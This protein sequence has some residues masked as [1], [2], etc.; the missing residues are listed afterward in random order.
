MKGKVKKWWDH[1][2]FG[3]I[4]PV[5]GGEDIFVHHTGIKNGEKGQK[6]L[7]INQDVNFEIQQGQKGTIAVDV[8]VVQ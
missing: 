8:E 1:K 6:N 3:F 7:M 4:E 5:G 2:G